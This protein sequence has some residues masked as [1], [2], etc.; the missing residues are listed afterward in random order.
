VFSVSFVFFVS[1]VVVLMAL[2]WIP[3]L[4]RDLTNGQET[5]SL[6]GSNVAHIIE[7]L[8]LAYPGI[9]DRLCDA[10]GLRPGIAVAVDTEL[11]RLGLLQPVNKDSEVHFLPAISGGLR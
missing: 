4:L 6:A 7:A 3:S 5:V 11:A 10:S 8:D 1:F 9:K 2:I